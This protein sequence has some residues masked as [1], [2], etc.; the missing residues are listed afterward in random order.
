[1]KVIE[2][3]MGYHKKAPV[4]I[5]RPAGRDNRREDTLMNDDL[6]I[7][8]SKSDLARFFMLID[9]A[10]GGYRPG[11]SYAVR[12]YTVRVEIC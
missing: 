3:E 7:A 2:R 10:P 11:R 8:G 6:K 9:K 1:M 12:F 5:L 4:M